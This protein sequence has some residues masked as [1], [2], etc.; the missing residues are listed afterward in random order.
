[1]T[2]YTLEGSAIRSNG[3][4]LAIATAPCTDLIRHA[5]AGAEI[6]KRGLGAGAWTREA[7]ERLD[8]ACSTLDSAAIPASGMVSA[9]LVGSV[10][11]SL[12][13]TLYD[14]RNH[15]NTASRLVP[16]SKGAFTVAVTGR[17]GTFIKVIEAPAADTAADVALAWAAKDTGGRPSDFLVVAVFAGSLTDAR[18]G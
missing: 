2:T 4:A 16:D 13:T 1:M 3:M 12:R 15:F 11:K 7:L 14:C 6:E 8:R 9:E 10:M 5:R 17:L 18:A